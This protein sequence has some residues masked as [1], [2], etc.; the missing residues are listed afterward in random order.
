M[1]PK[2]FRSFIGQVH[3]ATEAGDLSW[4]EGDGSAFYCD[5]KTHTLHISAHFDADREESSIHFRIVTGIK[6]T[7]F[8]VRDDEEDYLV[9]RRLYEA[10]VA[11]AND[12]GT[13]IADFFK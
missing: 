5:H 4:N 11:N 6:S 2:A 13:D 1:I 8:S 10:V 7:P 12:V 3:A 9:M